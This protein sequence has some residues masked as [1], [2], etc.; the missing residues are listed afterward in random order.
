MEENKKAQIIL[1]SCFEAEAA[2]LLAGLDISYLRDQSWI[3][4]SSAGGEIDFKRLK[5]SDIFLSGEEQAS[6]MIQEYRAIQK[7]ADIYVD[8]MSKVLVPKMCEIVEDEK[9]TKLRRLAELHKKE[10]LEF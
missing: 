7:L 6:K 4:V 8:V 10:K 2:P 1:D 9:P 3:V 5:N